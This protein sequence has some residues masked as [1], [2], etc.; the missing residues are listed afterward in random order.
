MAQLGM[1]GEPPPL[2][3]MPIADM[4]AGMHGVA[5]V[6]AALLG[7]AAS[8]KGQHIDLAL[9]DCMISMH[10]YAVQRY[11]LSGG[12]ELPKQTGR[13][14]PDS[15]VYGC[16]AAAD[17]YLVIAAQVD[18]SWQRL[19]GLIGGE[20]LAADER[21]SAPARRNAN[22]AEAVALVE[23]WTLAQPSRAACIAALDAAGVPCAPVS[24]ID[25][26]LAD[27]QTQARGMVIEQDHPVLGRIRLPNLPF[28]FSDCDTSPPCPAPL[29]GQHN[30]AIAEELG[31]SPVEIEAMVGDG[32]LYAEAAVGRL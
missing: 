5:A 7:R 4:Y 17:G 1:P 11:T 12:K 8:G 21:F 27:P 14:M 15:A 28:H 16:F 18:E 6:C 26:V 32:V 29:L 9:Y 24:R 20:A 23:A 22:S 13:D 19:A 3:R 30:R 25:E 10:D 2:F 31:Y